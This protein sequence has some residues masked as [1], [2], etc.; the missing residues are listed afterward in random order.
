[1][2]ATCLCILRK[3]YDRKS[4]TEQI[5][6]LLQGFA[7]SRDSK[8]HAAI[9]IKAVHIQKID[10][11]L[12]GRKPFM[13]SFDSVVKLCEHPCASALEPNGLVGVVDIAV[14]V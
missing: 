2:V 1:M 3:R 14:P 5:P 6:T 12:R 4:L 11:C 8:K 7:V 10:A 9:S 13:F